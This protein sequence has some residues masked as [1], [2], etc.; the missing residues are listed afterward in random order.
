MKKSFLVLILSTLLA[1]TLVCIQPIKAQYQGDIIINAEGSVI[2]SNTPI[3][4]SGDIYTLT[5]DLIGNIEVNRSN[6]VLDGNSHILTYSGSGPGTS[7][8]ISVNS[9]SNVTIKNFVINGGW[10]GIALYGNNCIINNNT[11]T[12]TGNEIYELD[13]STSAI[14]VVGDS[15]VIS[16]NYLTNNFNGIWFYKAKDNMVIGNTIKNSGGSTGR[17]VNSAISFYEASNNTIFH[18][19]FQNNSI[20]YTVQVYNSGSCVNIWDNGYPSGGNYWDDYQ[21]K[22]TNVTEINNTRIG[23]TAYVIDAQNR[24]NYPLLEPFNATALVEASPAPTE[25]PI[26]AESMDTAVL[27]GVAAVIVA[28]LAIAGLIISYK[29]QR[30]R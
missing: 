12:N 25:S 3:Q 15:N 4:Q 26:G 16:G 6:C 19:N 14:E 22:Y 7:I 2:P 23:D 24:D 20:N 13:A 18:N 27:F 11:I 9:V 5:S 30:P 8:T 10:F 21:T 17:M 1:L 28:I 29:K